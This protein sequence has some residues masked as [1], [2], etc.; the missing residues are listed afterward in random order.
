MSV[1]SFTTMISIVTVNNFKTLK[2]TARHFKSVFPFG[3]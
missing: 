3:G 1:I 2:Y